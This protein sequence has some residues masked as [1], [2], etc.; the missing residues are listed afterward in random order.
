MTADRPRAHRDDPDGKLLPRDAREHHRTLVLRTLRRS[1]GISRADIARATGLAR[2]TVSD[3]VGDLLAE[4]LVR[5]TGVR[6]TDRPGKPPTL[7]EIDAG[8]RQVVVADLGR[9][10]AVHAAVTDLA[11]RVLHRVE[12]GTGTLR[13]DAAV[14]AVLDLVR[15]AVDLAG[16]PLLGIGVGSPGVVDD[17][18]TVLRSTNAGWTDVP[19]GSLL[20][21]AHDLPVAVVND[22]DASALAEQ[23]EPGAPS[24][25]LVVRVGTGLGAGLVLAGRLVR[26]SHFRAGEFAQV[27][28]DDAG[29]SDGRTVEEHVQEAAAPALA[30]DSHQV[31][32]D[33]QLRMG[34]VLGWAL[35][36]VVGMLDVG[37]VVLAGDPR[38][39]TEV[40]T[41]S[42]A[43]ELEARVTSGVHRLSVRTSALGAD[44]V[45]RGMVSHLLAR[46][47]G[48]R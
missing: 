34:R 38:L 9:P 8:A 18:G 39:V 6:S 47:L 23:A 15:G 5:S 32:L 16:R 35:A 3:L 45:L 14:T 28:L 20:R 13:G 21:S 48:L 10:G 40:T 41:G 19:L 12:V 46:E 31:R 25:I 4:G 26:G 17:D 33:A 24:D 36:P 11:G 42:F 43:A 22:A 27:R 1:P 29:G 44:A 2:I 30:G 7:L 37:E